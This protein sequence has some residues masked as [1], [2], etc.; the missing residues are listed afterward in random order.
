MPRFAARLLLILSFLTVVSA[1]QAKDLAIS[2]DDFNASIQI[3][4][5]RF[6]GAQFFRAGGDG[7]TAEE[8][9]PLFEFC[10]NGEVL[11]SSSRI[12]RYEGR[13]TRVL[14]NGGTVTSFFFR[15]KGKYKALHICWDR[16]IFTK[17]ALIRERLRLR[18]DD[19]SFRFT[20][21]EGHNHFIFPR[22]T[23]NADANVTAEELRIASFRVKRSMTDHHMNH[24]DTKYYDLSKGP[25][26]TKGPFLI[27]NEG[28]VTVWTAY[29]HASQD[30]GFSSAKM[31]KQTQ[32]A[33]NDGQQGTQG[34]M[35][36]ITSDNLWFI[37]TDA[38]LD[39]DRMVVGNHIRRGAYL[40]GELLPSDG[41][42]ETVWSVISFEQSPE[43]VNDAI[44]DYL[45]TKITENPVSRDPDFY[46]NTWGMQRDYP[47][48]S[49]YLVMNERRLLDEID[50]AAECGV[51]TFVIDDGWH[52]TFGD[53]R[54]NEERFPNTLRPLVDRMREKGIIPG[55]WLSLCGAGK[56]TARYR[57]HPEWV[58]TDRQGK[59]VIG[60]W[61]NPV[62]DLVGPFYDAILSDLKVLTDEGFRFFKWDAINLF[63]SDLC[64]LGHGDESNTVQERIDRYNYLFPFYVTGLMRELREYCPGVVVEIDLTEV[65]RCLMGLMVLQ[66]GKYYF[67]NNGASWYRDYGFK[68]TKS[69]RSTINEYA[70]IMPQE[71]F[72]YAVYPRDD[73]GSLAYNTTTA[74]QAGHGLWG[75][76]EPTTPE[77]RAYIASKFDKAKKI[78]PHVRGI[79]VETKGSIHDTPETYIQCNRETAYALFTAFGDSCY[80]GTERIELNVSKVLGVLDCPFSTDES[81]VLLP[82]SFTGEKP[83]SV[84]A[85]V[86]GNDGSGVRVLS[87][88]GSLESIE[89]SSGKMTVTAKTDTELKILLPGRE[90]PLVLILGAGNSQEIRLA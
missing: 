82:L 21:L 25:I 44:G 10:I 8:Q 52:V 45:F 72:T 7:L 35:G 79:L 80:D 59:P 51:R 89:L 54:D 66:E 50:R 2:N 33:F 62:Y 71:L 87:S 84:E 17:D 75:N 20:N 70:F 46:Y 81:G 53:W 88:T 42:Y 40:D 48:D 38:S 30:N 31:K 36:E 13:D 74:L 49:L 41:W 16:E 73:E 69:V 15:G 77:Q 22:Y 55:I 18:S 60:Q 28:D 39:N 27:L 32:G 12:W 56:E 85:F 58:I 23:L 14:S 67:I 26:H 6:C 83:E 65:E 4:G 90:D 9:L 64:G 57:E 76:L 61:G 5:G 29:E 78:F 11:K 86:L 1:L 24:P 68:R 47:K 37:S 19:D 34:D 43:E 63:N 3:S